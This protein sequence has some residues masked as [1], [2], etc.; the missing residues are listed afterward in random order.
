[1]PHNPLYRSKMRKV[2][3]WR[4]EM[5]TRQAQPACLEVSATGLPEGRYS[6]STQNERQQPA[7]PSGG[8][9]VSWQ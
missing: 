9:S 4:E 5:R 7:Q 1:M 2:N 8:V 6:T 3:L